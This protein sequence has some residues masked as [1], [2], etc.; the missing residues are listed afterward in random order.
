M[1]IRRVQIE[2]FERADTPHAPGRLAR[3]AR[4][5]FPKH[6]RYLGDEGIV[7]AVQY[8]LA[9]CRSYGLVRLASVQLYLDLM[10]L[11][12]RGFDKDQ[13]LPW[14]AEILQDPLLKDEAQRA[15][16]LH[17]RAE[18]YLNRVS[19]P[20][21]EFIDAA[22]GRIGNELVTAGI[23][24]LD[25]FERQMLERL[26]RVFPEKCESIGDEAVR[27]V[28]RNAVVMARKYR[29]ENQQGAMLLAGLAFMLGSHFDTDPQFRSINR[30]LTDNEGSAFDRSGRLQEAAMKYLSEW[31]A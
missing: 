22:Q 19:G 16:R 26:L 6:C 9:T 17:A 15:S 31:C 27:T 30:V 18:E 25:E 29:V 21:N 28:V 23:S 4:Q 20:A 1:K 10:F 3:H 12:G 13:Q 2:E 14:A 8:A 11:L 24:T 7:E 5:A